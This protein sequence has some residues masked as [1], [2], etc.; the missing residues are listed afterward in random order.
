LRSLSKVAPKFE[1]L[2]TASHPIHRGNQKQI[3]HLSH[4]KFYRKTGESK[5]FL[6]GL[7]IASALSL[8]S[9]STDFKVNAPYKE[10]NAVYGL[11][12]IHDNA[13]IIKIGKVFQNG[14][15]LS[16]SQAARHLDSLY[17][18]DSLEVTLADNNTGALTRLSKFY[19]TLKEPGYF[20]SPGQYLYT[21]P[22]GFSLNPSHS[23]GLMIYDPKTKVQ[24]TAN[25]L[26]VNDI[27]PTRPLDG[28][29]VNL[30]LTPTHHYQVSFVAGSNAV[31]YDVNI[32]IPVREFRVKDST[33]IR[34]DTLVYT[35]LKSY[36]VSGGGAN[37]IQGIQGVQFYSFIGA[38]LK[39]DPTV[40]RKMD[41]L[42]FEITG[43]AQDLANYI[44]VNTP[45]QG[46]VQKKS[47]YTNISNGV[48]IFSSRLITH[49]KAPLTLASYQLLNT[50][51]YTLGLNFVQ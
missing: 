19:N 26:V 4:R 38:S 35:V 10:E 18:A 29:A 40:Y 31:T 32:Y 14:P 34:T 2:N 8:F 9:C 23:Y 22:A 43:A 49:I 47:D 42:D 36:Q 6:L 21:T 15:G 24:S 27:L 1:P 37:I 17:K 51:P 7:F 39:A 44:Q 3:M 28:Q 30:D 45:S 11:L 20:S 5:P 46:I 48:G 50:S 16:A 13:Q 41:S 25:T 33:L 12:E